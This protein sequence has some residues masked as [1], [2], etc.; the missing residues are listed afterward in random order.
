MFVYVFVSQIFSKIFKVERT[1][2]VKFSWPSK[3]FENGFIA[4][5][6]NFTFLFRTL[7]CTNKKVSNI[8]G[9]IHSNISSNI[10][11]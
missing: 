2:K 9:C 3:S 11:Q 5:P 7:M 8:Q 4:S 6:V 10:S 1:I